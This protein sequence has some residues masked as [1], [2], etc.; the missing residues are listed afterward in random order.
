MNSFQ[1]LVLG[2]FGFFII[3]G[4]LVI[5]TV[6]SSGKEEKAVVSMWGVRPGDEVGT[7]LEAFFED[8][9]T[10]AVTYQEISESIID[11][12]LVEA[13]AAGRGP[14]MVLLPA[15]LLLRYRDKITLI[16]YANYTE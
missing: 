13:F 14:D 16:P 4:L 8:S 1:T 6:K 3:A 9:E 7:F 15:E 5:A 12:Q 11:E 10:L 2:I